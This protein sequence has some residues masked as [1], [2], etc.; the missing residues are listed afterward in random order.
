V[1]ARRIDA[2]LTIIIITSLSATPQDDLVVRPMVDTTLTV[3]LVPEGAA[4]RGATWKP[5]GGST[6]YG[7]DY[8][9]GGL[10]GSTL[11]IDF[12]PI[13]GFIPPK[14][15]GIPITA[16]NDNF[17]NA[18]YTPVFIAD[19]AASATAMSTG[20]KTNNSYIGM[21]AT[22]IP[23]KHVMSEAEIQGKSTGVVTTVQFSHA[24]PA[25]FLAHNISRNNFEE[26]AKE[27]IL[28]SKADV[29]MGAGHP[30]YNN[31]GIHQKN[32][33]SFSYVGSH[34]LWSKLSHN[35]VGGDAD[36]DG[37]ADKWYYIEDKKHFKKL[38]KG[39]TPKRV[40]GLVRSHTTLQ[41]AR[42]GVAEE[43]RPFEARANMNVPTLAEM[44]AAALNVLD[45]NP[46]GFV[47]LIEAGAIDWACHGNSTN[48]LL[49]GMFGLHRAVEEIVDWGGA[50]TAPGKTHS[51]WSLL[52][53]RLV[54]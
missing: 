11:L 23:L 26:I 41:Y 37:K 27:M 50:I 20:V 51:W 16:G 30:F 35:K 7:D 18:N 48:G 4:L 36:G 9:L 24:T 39:K 28:Q 53:T 14:T 54:T 3:N 49:E 2:I 8:T 46:E 19:S 6:W 10:T 32:A 12:K 45:N 31:N 43:T 42:R 1:T 47:L 21:S 29:I 52:T 44:T 34:Y 15:I 40:F 25:G 5:V 38:G 17:H 33:I 22:G 13:S